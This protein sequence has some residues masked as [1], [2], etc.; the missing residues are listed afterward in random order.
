[1]LASLVSFFMLTFQPE[2][3]NVLRVFHKNAESKDGLLGVASG[4]GLLPLC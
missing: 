1:M 4:L 3:S 2:H